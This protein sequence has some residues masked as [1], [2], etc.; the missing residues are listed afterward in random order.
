M[1]KDKIN[2][3]IEKVEKI[4][5]SE[6]LGYLETTKAFCQEMSK[7]ENIGTE[8][9]PIYDFS[10]ALKYCQKTWL[11]VTSES[12]KTVILNGLK[13]NVFFG[14]CSIKQYQFISAN[15][16]NMRIVSGRGSFRAKVICET[17]P[18]NPSVT[19][20]WGVNPTFHKI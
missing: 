14:N 11:K 1:K 5:N 9:E 7:V 15:C 20:T 12:N 10:E 8:E 13:K 17:E 19:G 2:N 18:F 3:E 4:E 16:S 6:R